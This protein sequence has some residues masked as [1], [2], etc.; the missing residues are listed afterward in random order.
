MNF[1][2]HS[3]QEKLLKIRASDYTP[4][5]YQSFAAAPKFSSDICSEQRSPLSPGFAFGIKSNFA[6]SDQNRRFF[7]DIGILL[8]N[9]NLCQKWRE[10]Q[11]LEATKVVGDKHQFLSENTGVG[12]LFLLRS[13]P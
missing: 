2:G 7:L 13:L 8:R 10:I 3:T 4:S 5:R 12:R 1:R 6:L 11:R 9:L